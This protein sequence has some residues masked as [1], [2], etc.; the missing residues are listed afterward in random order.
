MKRRKEKEIGARSR[1]A[2]EGTAV[3]AEH[4]QGV[5]R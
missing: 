2:G 3:R 1:S 4:E 5:H